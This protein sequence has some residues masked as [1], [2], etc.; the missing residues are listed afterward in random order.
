M[1]ILYLSGVICIVLITIYLC[2]KKWDKSSSNYVPV[3]MDFSDDET[4]EEYSSSEEDESDEI[5]ESSEEE[6]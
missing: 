6:K 3:E 2:K 5:D 4:T 1:W